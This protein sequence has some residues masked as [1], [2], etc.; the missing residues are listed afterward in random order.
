MKKKFLFGYEPYTNLIG[1]GES[2]SEAT[3]PA[4]DRVAPKFSQADVDKMIGQ[5]LAKEKEA[6]TKAVEE[7]KQLVTQLEDLRATQGLSEA[8][9]ASLTTRIDELT[10]SLQT[11]EEQQQG[12]LTRV[13]REYETQVET[14]KSDATRFKTLFEQQSIGNSLASA[15]AAEGALNTQQIQAMFAGSVS[16]VQDRDP[17]SNELLETFTPTLKFVGLDNKKKPAQMELPVA[18]AMKKIREDG[19]NSNLFKGHQVSGGGVNPVTRNADGSPKLTASNPPR[20]S[21]YASVADWQLAAKEWNKL[22]NS[23]GA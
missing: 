9:K 14:Y 19:L 6:H 11:K 16:L 1:E 22:Y 8:D 4:D 20:K 2:E 21:D 12:E 7:K 18:E 10:S 3:P 5:R 23:K 13:K 15:A 17:E